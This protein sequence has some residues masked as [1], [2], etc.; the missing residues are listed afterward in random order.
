[1]PK[2]L[3]FGLSRFLWLAPLVLS[4]CFSNN[5]F[6]AHTASITTS[7][8]VNIEI[9]AAGNTAN[10]ATDN[11]KVI[12]SCPA[13]YTVSVGGGSDNTLY[14]DGNSANSNDN[15]KITAS[16]GTLASPASLLGDNLKTWGYSTIDGTTA[17]SSNFIGLTSTPSII[18]TSSAATSD[19]GDTI[20]VYYGASVATDT[21]AGTYT[22]AGDNT[23]TY[24]LNY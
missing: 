5:T 21:V 20:P 12:T 2:K 19:S 3:S 11:V 9:P 8:Q 7:G 10:M 14:K 23:I 18:K 17:T 13:G 1:M 4:F 6:A 24:Y 22:M 16:S 15:T